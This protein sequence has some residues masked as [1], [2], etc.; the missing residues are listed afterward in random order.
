MTREGG[1]RQAVQ[2]RVQNQT[3]KIQMW[4]VRWQPFRK[5]WLLAHWAS[6]H[7]FWIILNS[8]SCTDK[9]LA[10]SEVSPFV[11]NGPF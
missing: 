1:T 4:L 8:G 10:L 6:S 11:S 7:T 3:M 2:E 5:V 9:L